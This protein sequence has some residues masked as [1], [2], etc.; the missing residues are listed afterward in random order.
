VKRQIA[1]IGRA[2]TV[3]IAIG[4]AL[5]LVSLIPPVQTSVLVSSQQVAPE[6][7][8]PLSYNPFG[9][10]LGNMS[11]Y[12]TAFS[13]LTPQQELNVTL[14]CNGTTN[15]YLLKMNLQT[16]YAHLSINSTASLDAFLE[17]NPHV[18]GWQGEIQGEGTVDY[19]PTEIINA[20]LIFSNPSSNSI[21]VEY[22]GGILSLLAPASKAQT[23]ALWTI[24]IGFVLALPWFLDLWK[25]RKTSGSQRLTKTKPKQ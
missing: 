19:V 11:I 24:P 14:T 21:L 25:A 22:D 4:L 20:T 8:Q 15:V 6:T 2:G 9:G 23:V 5:L 18:I 17:A 10:S 1:L 7:F 3:L 12:I 16:L 13:T